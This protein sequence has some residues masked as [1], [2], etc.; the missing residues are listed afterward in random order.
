MIIL[1]FALLQRGKDG[2]FGSLDHCKDV[3]NNLPACT[4]GP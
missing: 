3:W 1:V 2:L 4:G